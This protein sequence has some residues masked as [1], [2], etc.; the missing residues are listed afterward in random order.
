MAAIHVECASELRRLVV[1]GHVAQDPGTLDAQFSRDAP[2]MMPVDHP[3]ALIKRHG[4][5]DTEALDARPQRRLGRR[6]QSTEE[7]H[8][9]HR[10]APLV[11]TRRGFMPRREPATRGAETEG[12][13]E[14]YG[15]SRTATSKPA[16]IRQSPPIP[17]RREWRGGLISGYRH[18][19]LLTDPIYRKNLSTVLA[20]IGEDRVRAVS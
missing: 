10:I 16:A 18:S 15:T 7:L 5:E 4:N 8:T 9:V 19:P 3:S 17:K 13:P 12:V 14:P 11:R 2:A 1:V 20:H 6:L